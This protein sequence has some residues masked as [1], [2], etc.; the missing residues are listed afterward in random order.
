MNIFRNLKLSHR[1]AVLICFFVFG[2]AVFCTWSF[3]TLNELKVNGPVY[4]R[5]VLGKDL[6]ADILPPPEYVIES[7]LVAFQL[8]AAGEKPERDALIERL[9][10]LKGEYDTRHELWL[11]EELESELT[12]AFLKQ[13]YVPAVAFYNIIFN[14]LIPAVEK[15]DKDAVSSVMARMKTSYEAHRK[16]IDQVV[17]M[18]TKRNEADEAQAKERIETSSM[19]LAAIFAGSLGAAIIVAAMISRSLLASLGGEPA[20]AAEISQRIAAGDLTMKIAV[21]EGD[22]D[23]L[24]FSMKTMQEKLAMTVLNIKVAVDSVNMG[25]QQIAAGNLDLATRTEE[26]AHSLEKTA[27]TMEELTSTVKQNADNARQA[28]QLA[29]SVSEVAVKGG[30]VV[31][32]AVD[33]MESI[34]ES[35]GKI[36]DIITVIEGIAFQTNILALNAAVEAA[37]AGEQGRGF[38][39]VAAEVRQLAQRSAAA[40]KEIKVM[41]DNSVGQVD[42]G[43]RLVD[44]AGVTMHENVAGVKKI[45]DI[46]SEITA[47]SQEQRTGIE[48]I[49]QT[50]AQM[51]QVT[52]QNAALVEEA[53]TAAESLHDQA[54]NLAR[55]V[56]VFKLDTDMRL[57]LPAA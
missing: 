14:E 4:Q 23:S 18:T 55:A 47:A 8:A 26:Q 42:H 48:Q 49:H 45:T 35:A 40:S 11:K 28:H 31:S 50:I 13:S 37:R 41:I 53:A 7:Y 12:E 29:Q 6:I 25:S 20:Y 33:T 3:K 5:I 36:T 17:Q 16:A 54:N 51:D 21:K 52:Q 32:Q 39:V 44:Q 19:L 9:K 1:F 38:A 43:A 10:A 57:A 34:S 22:R 2:F 56:S 24:L 30:A 46:I 15:Q 27:S